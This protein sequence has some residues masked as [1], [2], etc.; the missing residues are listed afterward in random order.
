MFL[1]MMRQYIGA[2][3]HLCVIKQFGT[4]KEKKTLKSKF[5]HE[6]IDTG[7]FSPFIVFA[8]RICPI[9][10]MCQKID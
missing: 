9:L 4:D 2:P 7:M 8:D 1:L 10:P 5:V 6:Y 3:Y